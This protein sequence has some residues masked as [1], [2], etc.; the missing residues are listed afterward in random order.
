M[1]ATSKPVVTVAAELLHER[2]E[3]TLFGEYRR[4][5]LSIGDEQRA[6]VGHVPIRRIIKREAAALMKTHRLGENLGQIGI[7]ADAGGYLPDVNCKLWSCS[8][9]TPPQAA[10]SP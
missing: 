3:L 9:V 4:S 5:A 1:P 10:A 8:W 7:A 2:R 6:N